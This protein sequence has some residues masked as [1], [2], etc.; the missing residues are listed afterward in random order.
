DAGQGL[1]RRFRGAGLLGRGSNRPQ[2]AVRHPSCRLGIPQ[3]G[4]ETSRGTRP[5]GTGNTSPLGFFLVLGAPGDATV[6]PGRVP[7][8]DTSRVGGS[9]A[10]RGQPRRRSLTGHETG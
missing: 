5:T 7:R 2:T 3:P 6:D 9:S 10:T 1:E 8:I 4:D